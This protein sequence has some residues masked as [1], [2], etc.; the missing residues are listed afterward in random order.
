MP[1]FWFL[2]KSFSQ[3][4]KVIPLLRGPCN[5]VHSEMKILFVDDF[6]V[7]SQR[8][9]NSS[10]AGVRVPWSHPKMKITRMCLPLGVLYTLRCFTT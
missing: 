10:G 5:L 7:T 3:E 8:A 6:L 9:A 1:S 2:L 4:F